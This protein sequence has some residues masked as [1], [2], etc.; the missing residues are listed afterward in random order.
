MTCP[1]C[2]ASI[3]V[4]AHA[5]NCSILAVNNYSTCKGRRRRIYCVHACCTHIEYFV[6]LPIKGVVQFAGHGASSER[7]GA[8]GRAEQ[9]REEHV[10]KE[11]SLFSRVRST[12]H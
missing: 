10:W 6:C 12:F 1:R 7:H 3:Q 2:T 9:Q 11:T 4:L 8:Q 5:K